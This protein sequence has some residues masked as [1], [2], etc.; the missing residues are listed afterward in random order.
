MYGTNGIT[1]QFAKVVAKFIVHRVP[2]LAHGKGGCCGVAVGMVNLISSQCWCEQWSVGA[3][4]PDVRATR[5]P[6]GR[7][8]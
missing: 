4:P 7:A 6:A 8:G 1:D 2:T 5:R 3:H